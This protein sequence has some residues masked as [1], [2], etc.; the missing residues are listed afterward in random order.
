LPSGLRRHL[1]RA[2]RKG[3]TC[4][5][6]YLI[7]GD[8]EGKLDVLRVECTKCA[9]KGRYSVRRL[10]E[11]YGRKAN[12]MKWKERLNGDCPR[13]DAHSVLERCDLVCPDL[14]KVLGKPRTPN[15]R[16]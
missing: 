6:T 14:P 1:A 11:K 12:M 3:T 15:A 5:A 10:I 8:I 9:R 16:S 13:R 2:L 7:F 4:P